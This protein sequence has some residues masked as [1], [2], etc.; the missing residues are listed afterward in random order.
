MLFPPRQ[1]PRRRRRQRG[2]EVHHVARD[3]RGLPRSS[4]AGGPIDEERDAHAAVKGAVRNRQVGQSVWTVM[5]DVK[6]DGQVQHSD[7]TVRATVGCDSRVR[8]SEPSRFFTCPCRRAAR[9]C[10]PGGSWDHLRAPWHAGWLTGPACDRVR[11]VRA[12][13]A[14]TWQA[15]ARSLPG[16]ARRS[17]GAVGYRVVVSSC[18]SGPHSARRVDD[19]YIGY[20]S[21]IAARPRQRADGGAAGGGKVGNGRTVVRHEEHKR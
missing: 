21:H 15:A 20:I 8:P 3:A 17:R 9:R 14:G 10:T 5:C 7:T 19:G 6:C 2:E 11:V 16:A 18:G 13:A 1:T 4:E 12:C